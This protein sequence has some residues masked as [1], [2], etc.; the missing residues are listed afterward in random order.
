MTQT[1]KPASDRPRLSRTELLLALLVI[2]VVGPLVHPYGFQQASRYTLTAAIWDDHAFELDRYDAAGVVGDDRAVKDGHVYSDKAPL[3]PV[4]AVP[5]YAAYRGVGGEPATKLRIEENLGLWWIT[6]W[7]AT[8]PAAVL[9]ALMYR[10]GRRYAPTDS[11]PAS[12]GLF[13]GSIL[14]PFAALLFGHT[15]GALFI[16]GAFVLLSGEAIRGRLLGAGALCGAAVA[17][18][19]TSAVAVVVLAGYALWMA[20]RRFGWFVAGGVP[21]AV[22]LGWYHTVVF[23]TP[24]THPY[25]YSAFNEVTTEARGVF[26]IF[27]GFQPAHVFQVFVDGRG[28]LIATPMVIVGLV[29]LVWVLRRGE[30]HRAEAAVALAVFLAFLLIPAFWAN[31][32]G[33]DSPGARYMTPALPFLVIGAAAIWRRAGILAKFS[34]VLGI[35]TMMSALLTQ[36]LLSDEVGVS[37]GSWVTY[38]GEM[39]LVP[40]LFTIAVGPAGWVI[41]F[42]LVIAVATALLR[43][44]SS[45]VRP[46]VTPA[47]DSG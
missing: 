35:V 23:G 21:F 2:V 14:L 34:A 16:F 13:F 12:V 29:G 36:P 27:S 18:E 5:F 43:S 40:N 41:Y 31:P 45:A 9:A 4:I 26:S 37:V 20:R 44:G 24:L 17:A 15:L 6:F 3:Q 7:M 32:W 19:Y 1:A 11:L 38:A 47:G 30:S 22:A 25:R 39:G 33:G 8:I 28:F 42:G 10:V 46:V